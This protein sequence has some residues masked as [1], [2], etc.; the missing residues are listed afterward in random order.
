MP[1]LPEVETVR[2]GLEARVLGRRIVSVEVNHSQVIVGSAEEFAKQVQGVIRRLERKGKAIA[3][4]LNSAKLDSP[5]AKEIPGLL[6]RALRKAAVREASGYILLRLGMTGQVTVVPRDFPV[7]DHTHVR[8]LL[9][10]GEEIRYRDIRRFGRLRFCTAAEIIAVFA[11]MGPDAPSMNVEEF[12]D[13]LKGRHTPIK[14]WLLNQGRL[15]GVGNIYADESLFA[16][17]IHP[18]AEAGRLKRPAALKLHHAVVKV[19]REAVDKQ[20]TSMRDYIDIDGNPGRYAARLKVY[21]RTGQPCLRCGTKIQ[22][23]VVGGRSSHFCPWCQ[24]RPGK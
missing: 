13:S 5:R 14:N 18:F 8:L 7:E 3:I 11:T 20:G 21:Q 4:E 19:L 17:G 15:A 9:E 12:L 1:E 16:A 23:V 2:R 22:R 6:R 24:R 10:N